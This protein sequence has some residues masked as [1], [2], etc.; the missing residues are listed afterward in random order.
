MSLD[1]EQKYFVT[2]DKGLYRAEKDGLYKLLDVP[3]YGIAADDRYLYLAFFTVTH[4]T[5][6]RGDLAPFLSGQGDPRFKTIYQMSVRNSNERMHAAWL[7]ERYLWCA[8]TGRNSLLRIDRHNLA[9]Q[10]EFPLFTDR[11]GYP[12][13]H[14]VNHINGISEYGGAVL[15][16]AYRAGQ[17]A[18]IGVFDGITVTGYGYPNVG[19]HDI[20]MAGSDFVFC[21]TFGPGEAPGGGAVMTAEGAL[22]EAYF[23][24]G[25]GYVVRGLAGSRDELLIGHS[26]KG[27][28][29]KRFAGNGGLLLAREGRVVAEQP[30]DAAQV[31]QIMTCEGEFLQPRPAHATIESIKQGLAARLG[32]PIFESDVTP[33]SA[34]TTALKESAS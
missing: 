14:D 11:F 6:V 5:L 10:V 20:Y 21:D 3:T 13:L 17:Q 33:I 23:S 22:D 24:R 9:Q 31:Y 15:F 18:M 34:R 2:T 19:I 30:L 28:R 27:D 12:L 1:L 4:S 16:S 25:D 26:H 32:A 8:N 7:G 29:R